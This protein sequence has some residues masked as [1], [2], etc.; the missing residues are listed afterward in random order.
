MV[1]FIA[2]DSPSRALEFYDELLL[3]IENIPLSPFIYRQKEDLDDENIREFI[4]KGYVV[5]FFVDQKEN[6]IVILGIF[7]QN[8]W[9][10]ENDN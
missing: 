4:F 6:K 10:I 5:P 1:L 9:S 8:L 3:K 2:E 7:S